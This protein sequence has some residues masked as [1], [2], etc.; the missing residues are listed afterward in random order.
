MW[1][2]SNQAYGRKSMLTVMRGLSFGTIFAQTQAGFENLF[3]LVS[4]S[5]VEYFCRV[6]EF[7]RTVL[8]KYREG[9]LLGT[10]L[11]IGEKYFTERWSMGYDQALEKARY[12]GFYW[13]SSPK[14]NYAPLLEQHV[15]A[16]EDHL[17]DIPQKIWSN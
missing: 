6:P 14:P 9:L 4:L 17:E 5:N 7:R 1:M 2:I 16:D 11:F 8:T 13:R 15:I 12:Y 3:K 10:A